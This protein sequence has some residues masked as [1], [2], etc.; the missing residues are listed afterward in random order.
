VRGSRPRGDWSRL[1]RP[2]LARDNLTGS[3]RSLA[4]SHVSGLWMQPNRLVPDGVREPS[5]HHSNGIN[6]PP[7]R[8]ASLGCVRLTNCALTRS[9]LSRKLQSLAWQPRQPWP[10]AGNSPAGASPPRRCAPSCSLTPPPRLKRFPLELNRWDSRGF[11][12]GRVFR[13]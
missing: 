3:L 4:L 7:N 6:L 1:D 13:H 8:Q 12:D 11:R 10:C 5:P 2:R 9:L